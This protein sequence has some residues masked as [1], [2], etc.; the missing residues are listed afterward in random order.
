[1]PSLGT[2]LT[3]MAFSNIFIRVTQQWLYRFQEVVLERRVNALH[4]EPASR[5]AR[6]LLPS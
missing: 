6:G 4:R 3:P 1:M 5:A 2:S